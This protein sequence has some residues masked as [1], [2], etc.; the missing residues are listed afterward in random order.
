M[1]GRFAS[2]Y[3][4][5]IEFWRFDPKSSVKSPLELRFTRFLVYE[6]WF[7][8]WGPVIETP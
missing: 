8:E 4:L 2:E 3:A 6:W 7:L 5:P 1:G